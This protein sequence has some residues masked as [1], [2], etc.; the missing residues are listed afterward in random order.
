MPRTAARQKPV[1]QG[2]VFVDE[3]ASP[4]G[5]GRACRPRAPRRGVCAPA[6]HACAPPPPPR[7]RRERGREEEAARRRVQGL[8]RGAAE[9]R[10]PRARCRA[11]RERSRA[12]GR[13]LFAM[14]DG[15]QPADC[16]RAPESDDEPCECQSGLA[17]G[18]CCKPF[19]AGEKWPETPLQLMRS[20]CAPAPAPSF[21]RALCRRALREGWDVFP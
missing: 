18:Q 6:A 1:A 20:R 19:H 17:Y 16:E 15:G 5:A 10:E 13:A 4:R 9:A 11:A 21:R 3:H 2:A 14:R 7:R 8:R 12:H